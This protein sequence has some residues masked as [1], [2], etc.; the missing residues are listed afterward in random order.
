MS[1]YQSALENIGQILLTGLEGTELSEESSAFLSQARVGGVLLFT[2]NYT[3]PEQL[4]NLI[5]EIQK[6][7]P[8]TPFWIA[9][10]QEGGRVQRFK[11][12]FS[13][14]PPALTLAKKDSPKL[15]Y[16]VS[17]VIAK[18][19]KAVGVNLN[20]APVADIWTNPENKVIGDRAF[21]TD[22]TSVTKFVTPFLRGHLLHR[23]Q[24]CVKHFPG[25]GDT[26][27]DSHFHLP[28]IARSAADLRDRELRPFLKA[29]RSHCGMVMT[30]HIINSHMDPDYP[31]TLSS[32]TLFEF[33]RKELRY[34]RVIVSDD[35]EMQAITDHFGIEDAPVLALNASCDLLIYRTEKAA[36]IAYEALVRAIENGALRPERV[37]EAVK[38][39]QDLKRDT[40]DSYKPGD[41]EDLKLLGCPEHQ[42]VLE[43]FRQS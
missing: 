27:E 28:K 17:E 37:L 5:N 43:E 31:A 4:Q 21:G 40:F 1:L 7:R 22:E 9:A 12:P 2:K 24:A 34:S 6:C 20:F 30:A 19:L 35:L 26:T 25:H 36:R 8:E 38:R 15:V 10:D 11:A 23:V 16:S 32:K 41:P 29:F 13:I 14:V 3:D 18:E 33:L 39:S 42:A